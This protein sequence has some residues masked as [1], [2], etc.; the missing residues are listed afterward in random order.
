MEYDYIFDTIVGILEPSQLS[1]VPSPEL[2]MSS[3]SSTPS[4]T[5]N[6]MTSPKE[7]D[8]LPT[9]SPSQAL[10]VNEM[11]PVIRYTTLNNGSMVYYCCCYMFFR[12]LWLEQ[13]TERLSLRKRSNYRQQNRSL[14]EIFVPTCLFVLSRVAAPTSLCS[15]LEPIMKIFVEEGKGEERGVMGEK[16]RMDEMLEFLLR[17]CICP[18]PG[19]M[20][21]SLDIRG[22]REEVTVNT[23]H[24]QLQNSRNKGGFCW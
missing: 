21:I 19:V 24:L 8:D 5:P 2:G 7:M 13:T 12:K 18:I 4:P 6:C 3:S 15:L 1:P 22:N 10:L 14:S 9:R 17:D 23:G 16:R 11:K 20:G